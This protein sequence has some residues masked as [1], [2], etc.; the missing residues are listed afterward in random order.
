MDV[1]ISPR[2]KFFSWI[3][4]IAVLLTDFSDYGEDAVTLG[5]AASR[6]CLRSGPRSP[7][8]WHDWDWSVRGSCLWSRE[9]RH[10]LDP[11]YRRTRARAYEHVQLR[12]AHMSRNR[13]VI[14]GVCRRFACG[15]RRHG[16][17]ESG[18]VETGLGIRKNRRSERARN[19]LVP[20][21]RQGDPVASLHELPPGNGAAHAD[22]QVPS[23]SAPGGSRR[24]G[25]GAAGRPRLHD[26]PS[27]RQFRSCRS[28]RKSCVASRS[29]RNGM[30]GTDARSDL[31][32]DQGYIAQRRQG[33]AGA[34]RTH[35]QG[36]SRRLGVVA[37]R[38]PDACTGNAKSVRGADQGVGRG[39]SYLPELIVGARAAELTMFYF[40]GRLV[41]AL[42]DCFLNRSITSFRC[43]GSA[44]ELAPCLGSASDVTDSVLT[45]LASHPTTAPVP[46]LAPASA[47]SR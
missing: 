3:Y 47:D 32:P 26:V 23:A 44:E 28:A 36:Q 14:A 34:G 19:R 40:L 27:R 16:H 5:Y 4:C 39:W 6:A 11:S 10:E 20:G 12:H 41:L 22:R 13:R 9:H 24:G 33:H 37:G 1:S 15:R 17:Q 30:A 45:P 46:F 42:S 8:R 21:S 29:R 31:C 18:D 2:F 38:E 7:T 25:H 35:G 43:L